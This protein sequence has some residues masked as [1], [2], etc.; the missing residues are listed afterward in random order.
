M[1]NLQEVKGANVFYKQ[2]SVALS[3]ISLMPILQSTVDA[4][5]WTS[6][7]DSRQT[8]QSISLK[9]NFNPLL[10]DSIEKH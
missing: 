6:S 8:V 3:V 10:L 7:F 1:T 9:L 5:K 4:E 2:I